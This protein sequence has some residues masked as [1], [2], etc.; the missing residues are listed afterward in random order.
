MEQGGCRLLSKLWLTFGTIAFVMS[1]ALTLPVLA[2]KVPL[3]K[4]WFDSLEWIRW[5]LVVHVNLS[6][7]VWFTAIPLGILHH[8]SVGSA[9]D[10]RFRFVWGLG[11]IGF[12]L[13]VLGVILFSSSTPLGGAEVVL[14]NYLPVMNHPR[15]GWGLGLYFLGIILNLLD[16]RLVFPRITVEKDDF[17][18]ARFGLGV[19]CLF[20]L[21]AALSIL[22]SFYQARS[23][24]YV[25]AKV[26]YEM[27]MW[28]GGHFIQHANAIFLMAVWIYLLSISGLEPRFTRSDVFPFFAVMG[29][30]LFVGSFLHMW[31]IHSNDFREGFTA[32]MQWGIAPP[33][34]GFLLWAGWRIRRAKS[35]HH[36]AR[37]PLARL[38]FRWSAFLLILGVVFGVG[39]R[40]SDMRIPAHYHATIGAV[41]MAYMFMSYRLLNQRPLEEK[42]FARCLW[43]YGVGQ[44]LFASGMFVLGSFGIARKTYGSEL[45]LEG[46]SQH[47]GFGLMAVGG[48]G[49]LTGGFL[50]AVHF[51][52][53]FVLRKAFRKWT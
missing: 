49:A 53:T 44:S 37:E 24:G 18:S 5:S 25:N 45:Q 20:V 2:G 26:F 3:I 42:L 31:P 21:V 12:C 14:S 41:T 39:I 38:A 4:N 29:V 27:V 16:V 23:V 51:L 48:L 30:P 9:T 35:L 36:E 22:W 50:F 46:I 40:G 17:A 6:N 19:G 10:P 52:K 13:S 1:G 33:M 15:F 7:L 43:T 34:L 47:L 8:R 11:F 32:L 28:G